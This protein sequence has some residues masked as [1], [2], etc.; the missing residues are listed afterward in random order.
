[1]M[2]T[3]L[4]KIWVSVDKLITALIEILMLINNLFLIIASNVNLA[5]KCPVNRD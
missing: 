3:I 5:V 2:I 1:M 4:K